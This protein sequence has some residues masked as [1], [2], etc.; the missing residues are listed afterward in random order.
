[1]N[2]VFYGVV[3]YLITK[4]ID[5]LIADNKIKEDSI[6]KYDL[7]TDL[8]V[9][10]INDAASVS[11]FSEK[12]L[13][14]VSNS[15]IFTGN[16]NKGIEQNIEELDKY[17]NN[18]NSDTF[19]IFIVNSEKLDER[20]KITKLIK[21]NGIV[22]DFNSVDTFFV[23]KN[24]F[25]DYYISDENVKYLIKRVGEDITL[26][27]TEINKIK[28]YKDLDKNITKQ[29][30]DDLTCKSMEVNNFKLID[31]IIA[32]DKLL[33]INLYNERLKLNEEP[34]AIIITLAN[35]IRIMYQVKQLYMDGYTENKIASILKIHPYRVKLASNNA[36]KHD[37]NTLLSYIKKLAELDIRI[38]TGSIDKILGMEL[39]ILGL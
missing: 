25:D 8:L 34:I 14:I 24:L 7:T 1:M 3:D 13:I 4:E 15:Y 33:A 35:Q 12:K 31:S 9:S 30:I 36:K 19:L 38:K 10:V 20:K 37:S 5:K 17:L 26:L 11:L 29:D 2:Y 28:L 39:F 32:K 21:K 18:S 22:K 23:V 27:S 16:T 6:I